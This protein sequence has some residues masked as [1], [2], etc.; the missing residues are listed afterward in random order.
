MEWK[1]KKVGKVPEMIM[2]PT[3]ILKI[4]RDPEYMS[5]MKITPQ[6]KIVITMCKIEMESMKMI[7]ME[8]SLHSP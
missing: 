7:D 5:I 1:I 8:R 4:K 2:Q 3:P 6:K